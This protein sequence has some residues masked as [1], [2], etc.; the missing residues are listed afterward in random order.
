MGE[1]AA[2]QTPAWDKLPW[3][4]ILGGIIVI[5]VAV[6]GGGIAY[7]EPETL[8]FKDYVSTLSDL[9]IGVGLV[10]VGRGV[11]KAGKHIAKDNVSR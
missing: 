5:I 3:G 8:T 2:N 9:A 1:P 4:T 6:V 11:S 7:F 10:T